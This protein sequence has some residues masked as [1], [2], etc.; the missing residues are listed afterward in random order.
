MVAAALAALVLPVLAGAQVVETRELMPGVVYT[1]DVRRTAA[2]PLVVHTIVAPRPGG[3]YALKPVLSND[4]ILGRETVSAMQQRIEL[5]GTTA[6][7][8][9]DLFT[10][11]TG[12]P[13]GILVRNGV[14]DGRPNPGRST[15]GI[16][17]DGLLRVMR[18]Q[19][20]G[21]WRV[22]DGE[23]SPLDQI[24]KEIDPEGD[25]VALFTPAWG[26]RTPRVKGALDVVLAAFPAAT[27]D[28]DLTGQVVL[29]R[30]GGGTPIPA[31]GAVVQATGIRATQLQIDAPPGAAITIR[32]TLKPW[33][34]DV[35]DA[36]GGGP[37]IVRDGQA[38]VGDEEFDSSQLSPRNPRTAV[39]QLADGRIVLVAVDGRSR[40]S[41]G[42]RIWDLAR[43]LVRQGA[44]TA[45]ALDAGGSTTIAFD[46]TVLNTP[47]D[48]SE[49]PVANALMV[50][51]YGAFLPEPRYA[52]VSPNGDGVAEREEGLEYKV[53]RPSTV[54]AKL[55]A[56]DGSIVWQ[57]QAVR[58]PGVYPVPEGELVQ[59]GTYTWTIAAT[60]DQGLPSTM[61][62]TFTVNPTLGFLRLSKRF[63]K[64]RLGRTVDVSFR[65]ANPA[66]VNVLVLNLAG[67][68]VRRL[69]GKRAEPGDL[70]LTWDGRNNRGR[71][72]APGTYTVRVKAGNALGVV[73]DARSVDLR[74]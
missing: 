39:G 28:T 22:A 49:R 59:Q 11:D 33:W 20:F 37:V 70:V 13:S 66:K 18:I 36:I 26:D 50:F 64:P 8:N 41:R 74:K 16:G 44:L 1:K 27:P 35:P 45:M 68:A 73:A 52:L 56:P 32:L 17:L 57:E 40:S 23:S 25:E 30:R 51:Y 65:L 42:V 9:G 7:V 29:L 2:G 24:N 62:R 31:G 38:V 53:V 5:E 15:L 54:D 10:W 6:G 3:L 43:E 67:R 72:L 14:V 46:G 60:D 71:L 47:S 63:F 4:R 21:S 55:L 19:F 48:G 58:D 61:T 12:R 69:Y 34:Q